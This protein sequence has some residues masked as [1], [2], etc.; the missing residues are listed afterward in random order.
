[1]VESRTMEVKGKKT[2]A[3]GLGLMCVVG[4][5]GI[6]FTFAMCE[7]TDRTH[8]AYELDNACA[9]MYCM[10]YISNWRRVGP[11][12]QSNAPL[13][14]ER[15][16]RNCRLQG[17]RI[18]MVELDMHK[19]RASR[20]ESTPKSSTRTHV[21]SPHSHFKPFQFKSTNLEA[22]HQPC[23]SSTSSSSPAQPPHPQPSQKELAAAPS[24]S[25]TSP[26]STSRTRHTRR[27]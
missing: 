22:D 21:H 24:T 27:K 17:R 16:G 5:V 19:T 14:A 15:M 12:I 8:F 25:Q 13:P 7:S 18:W 2:E 23:T 10:Y 1:M 20:R 9:S 26:P 11:R 3:M 6:A 4:K